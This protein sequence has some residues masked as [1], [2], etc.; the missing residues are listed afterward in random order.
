MLEVTES[1]VMSDVDA[2]VAP[3]QELRDLGVTIAGYDFGTGY[4]SLT[5]LKRFPVTSLKIDRSFVSGPGSNRD[6]AAMVAS[7]NDLARAV[8]LDCLAQG[9]ET[10]QQRLVLQ[11]LGCVFGQVSGGH[12]PWT[13]GLSRH[14]WALPHRART[15][16]RPRAHAV[17]G[18]SAGRSVT[19]DVRSRVAPADADVV[20]QVGELHANGVSMGRWLSLKGLVELTGASSA[21]QAPR[22]RRRAL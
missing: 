6:D 21:S 20:A 16:L 10:G 15:S 4:S 18:G 14:G 12:R 17:G 1:A 13:Y 7:F 8:Q 19:V 2:A 5:Y 11:A 3:V 9:A 22:R